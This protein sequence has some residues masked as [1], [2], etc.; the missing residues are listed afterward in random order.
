MSEHSE[1]K[2]SV[3]PSGFHDNLGSG[4]DRVSRGGAYE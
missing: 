4:A 1:S 2:A 3:H